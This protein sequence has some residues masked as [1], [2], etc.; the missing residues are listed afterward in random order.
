MTTVI[1]AEKRSQGMDY[2]KA[3]GIK[4]QE[5]GYVELD[6]D[7]VGNAIV[8]WAKG[9]LVELKL[10]KDYKDPIN[11]WNIENLP[12]FPNQ[13][14]YAVSKS[15]A[16]QFNVVKKLLN[17]ADTIINATDYGREGSNIFYSILRLSGA[18]NKTI[19][20]YANSSLV[21]E[22]IRKKF[23]Q[24]T[25]NSI[26]LNMYKEA[27]TRQISD[28]LVGMNLTSLYTNIFRNKGLQEVF[29]IGRVQTPTLFMIYERQ[30]EI[31]NFV[32][33]PFYELKGSFESANGKYEGKAKI[34]TKDKDEINMLVEKHNL[35]E[36]NKGFVQKL[37][38]KEKK[39][40]APS[41]FSLSGL[42]KKANAMF[43]ITSKETLNI[44]Q[45]L[46]D[47]KILTYPR[48]DT[49]S[50]T[51]SEFDYLIDKLDEYKT[52]Y[53]KNFETVYREAREPFVVKAIE[54]H[55]AIIPTS[56]IPSNEEI[57]KL[58]KQEKQV[59]DLVVSTTL[60]MFANDYIF[61]ETKVETNVN[62]MIFYTTGKI[63]TNIG[64]KALF[65]KNK[66]EDE[67]KDEEKTEKLPQLEKNEEVRANVV[68]TEG[69]TQPP[70]PFT[71]GQLIAMMETAGKQLENEDQAIMKETNGLGTESTRA[72]TIQTLI[73]REYIKMS[74]N[75]YY[76]TPKG[77]MLCTA[78]QNTLLASPSMTAE[79]EKRLKQIGKGE[80]DKES[81]VNMIKQFIK[82]ELS[83]KEEKENNARI[84]DLANQVQEE[85]NIAKC[86]NCN[87]GQIQKRGKVYKCTNCEQVFY[88]NF[89][90]KK[91]SES[92]VKEIITNGKTK[93][94][95]KLPK[96]DGGTYEAYLKLEDDKNKGTKRYA[97]S[98]D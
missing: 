73:A 9:H 88:G 92:Q 41:L 44:A 65:N 98:F 72:D 20:R 3:L 76:V 45:S 81:F 36:A 82:K 59:L 85:N 35:K 61:D 33:E 21:H 14:E 22:D 79:W 64:W 54:E 1:L 67:S 91:L 26:D 5:N 63:E 34:K 43:K 16:S 47:K 50:I 48:T 40:G 55:H 46:Y 19:K 62:E 86:P 95:I 12:F 78:V 38:T 27:N 69:K 87:Q 56:K 70:K 90:K 4:K 29:S 23:K 66:S 39:Q 8:T 10:P 84:G 58:S 15:K 42:Q 31:E 53:G 18:K 75:R 49:P 25:D 28:Y 83:L 71:D 13:F 89:F 2:A 74:K 60:S 6:S 7:I 32:S 37:E 77:E 57:N 51:Q 52:F 93:K 80:A 68:Q 94:K 97:V 96:K 11:T 17:D 24:L 30:K